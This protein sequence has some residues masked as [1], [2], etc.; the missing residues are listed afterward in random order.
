LALGEMAHEAVPE[1]K[2]LVVEQTYKQDP[3]WPDMG[4]AIDIWCPYGVLLIEQVLTE[5]LQ[6]VTKFGLI[7]HWFSRLEH[8]IPVM[9]I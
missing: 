7:Q 1:L 5:E 6:K 2:C 4:P 9:N 8:I 3:S